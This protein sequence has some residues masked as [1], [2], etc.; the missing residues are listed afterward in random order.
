MI[1]FY[2]YHP[3]KNMSFGQRCLDRTPL[4]EEEIAFLRKEIREIQ[5]DESIFVFNDE[6]H[7]KKS[8]CY[9]VK[10]DKIYITRNVYPD[11]KSFS[12]HPRDQMSPRA[13]LGHEYYGHKPQRE[14]YLKEA[15]GEIEAIPTWQDEAFAS[16]NAAFHTPNLDDKDRVLLLNDAA[17]RAQEAGQFFEFTDE[18][19]EIIYGKWNPPEKGIVPVTEVVVFHSYPGGGR[20]AEDG[21][22]DDD[23]PR[24]C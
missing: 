21:E 20:D 22:S 19:K 14:R 11:T 2:E 3:E 16:I 10:N 6:N 8:T 15:S 23:M 17:M 13:V 9:D 18:M 4:T 24:M 7:I 5:A 1:N 12:L